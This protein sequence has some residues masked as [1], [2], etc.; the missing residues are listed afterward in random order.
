MKFYYDW[1]IEYS[2]SSFLLVAI[3]CSLIIYLLA[4]LAV[5]K[6]I[7]KQHERTGRVLF[8]TTASLLALLLSLSFANQRVNYYKIKDALESEA[9]QLVDIWLDLQ[10]YGTKEAK[11][12]Q[13]KVKF[14][15]RSILHED[16]D[17]SH[18]NPLFGPPA[19]IFMMLYSQISDLEPETEKQARLKQNLL[20]DVDEVSDFMQ[21]RNY[22]SKP[23]PLFLIYIAAFGFV[24]SSI[25]FS[26]YPPDRITI[27]F[28][29]L[30]NAF[31]AIVLF[32]I[33]MM[34]NPLIG[35][36]KIENEP[37]K[38]IMELANMN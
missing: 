16:I 15:I 34:N 24:V 20:A 18:E 6:R 11:D 22:R 8:R 26:V 29:T 32:F 1:P 38:M 17:Y 25:L 23:E 21:V 27:S 33:I 28:F 30:Y 9:S 10:L 35:P 19:G 12:L 4:R 7:N 13:T 2:L 36:L 37:F 5:K 3:I 31:V 14:Y